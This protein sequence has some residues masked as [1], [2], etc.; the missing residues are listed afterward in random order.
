VTDRGHEEGLLGLDVEQFRV[1]VKKA[2]GRRLVRGRVVRQQQISK[3][4]DGA[5]RVGEAASRFASVGRFR[6]LDVPS[7]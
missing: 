6:D 4:R 7:D 2:D 3:R 5:G 1:A